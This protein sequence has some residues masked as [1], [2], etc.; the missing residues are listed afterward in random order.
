MI[1]DELRTRART[2][3][4]F[5][6]HMWL[7]ICFGNALVV[8]VVLVAVDAHTAIVIS[9]SASLITQFN[10]V[11]NNCMLQIDLMITGI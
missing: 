1:I 2:L 11:Y 4:H 9:F 10:G 6:L 7:A 8:A 3:A 5:H